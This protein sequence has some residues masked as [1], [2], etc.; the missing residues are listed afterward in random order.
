MTKD[1]IN[2]YRLVTEH[3]AP[4]GRTRKNNSRLSSLDEVKENIKLI[5]K[6][7]GER[8]ISLAVYE[9]KKV[10]YEWHR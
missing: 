7:S 3:E 5:L 8:L 4:K 10:F 2:K 1:I 6:F 9:G